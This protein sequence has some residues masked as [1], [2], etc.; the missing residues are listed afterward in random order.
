M[1]IK[2]HQRKNFMCRYL[3]AICL[4]L[5]AN[6]P[7]D[8]MPYG[9]F[10]ART[11][12]MGGTAVATANN[13]LGCYYN[14]AL[15]ATYTQYKEGP[16]RTSRLMFP[17]ISARYST[18]IEDTIDIAD[19]D[20]DGQLRTAI[21]TYNAAQTTMNAQGVVDSAQN[22]LSALN[23][24]TNQSMRLD[25]N[26]GLAVSI[27][28]KK[29]GG[30]FCMNVRAVG[31]GAITVPQADLQ[32][33][34]RYVQALTYVATSGASGTPDPTLFT[35]GNIN[36]LTGNLTSSASAR[37]LIVLQTA[38]AMSGEFSFFRKK[39][40]LGITPKLQRFS[41]FDSTVQ[42]NQDKVS[43]SQNPEDIWHVNLDAGAYM[44]LD[45]HWRTGLSIKNLIPRTL[46]TQQNN[47]IKIEPQMRLGLAYQ[48]RDW[49]A[50][51]DIDVL[52]NA[53]FGNEDETRY[54]SLGFEW[55]AW[56]SIK[57]RAGYSTNLADRDKTGLI[58]GGLGYQTKYID[59]EVAYGESAREKA[60]SLQ[61]SC[62]F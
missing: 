34:D 26:L 47:T 16:E 25:A 33:V 45:Q 19:Q 15:L 52:S 21:N 20:L 23:A 60:A 38:L 22:L 51:L 28:S 27:P 59:I 13:P 61:F 17:S 4:C 7:I 8:A 35:G 32:L 37:G 18:S 14:P 46:S 12:A 42:V 54:G 57:L 10:D 24:I 1:V 39:I 30:A 29:Q 36:D 50:A 40:A 11:L 2:A 41:T 58:T 49:L 44:E 55:Q 53:P 5:L 56:R 48:H 43:T 31:G 9:S 3:F 62:L 6:N